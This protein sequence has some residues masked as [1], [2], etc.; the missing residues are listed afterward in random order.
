MYMVG[1][2]VLC[3]TSA[4]WTN[5][6]SLLVIQRNA[7]TAAAAAAAAAAAVAAVAAVY[8]LVLSVVSCFLKSCNERQLNKL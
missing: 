7:A 1:Y 8:R 3:Q 5:K 6:P 2:R 4:L